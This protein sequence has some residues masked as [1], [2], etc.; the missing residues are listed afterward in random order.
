MAGVMQ[1][2]QD[3]DPTAKRHRIIDHAQLAMQAAPAAWPQQ[4][5]AAHRRENLPVDPGLAKALEQH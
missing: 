4:A 1:I 5:Q 2:V 3:V